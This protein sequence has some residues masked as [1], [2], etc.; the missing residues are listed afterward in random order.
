MTSLGEKISGFNT[1]LP[2]TISSPENGY[3]I[4]SKERLKLIQKG[5]YVSQMCKSAVQIILLL[6]NS[7]CN[8]F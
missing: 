5:F 1:T 8:Y 7:F 2:R 3:K 6:S 4:V